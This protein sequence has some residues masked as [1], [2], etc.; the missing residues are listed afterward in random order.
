VFGVLDGHGGKRYIIL[1]PL[2]S[3][4]VASNFAKILKRMKSYK[5][6][7]YEQALIEAYVKFDELL[8]DE[9][10]NNFLREQQGQRYARSAHLVLDYRFE[11][12]FGGYI[13]SPTMQIEILGDNLSTATKSKDKGSSNDS[14]SKE[15]LTYGE[16]KLEISMRYL[17]ELK[18]DNLVATN[19]GTTANILLMKNNYLY[20][21]NVGDSLAVLFKNGEAIK[22]NNE[23]KTSLQSEYT[24]INKSGARIINNR[25]EGRLNLTRAI[26]N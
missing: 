13:K 19:M 20:L 23:H 3:K 4:F 1:G 6:K 2:V 15:I 7:N 24:R 8:R 26:G 22:L 14:K 5:E 16:S 18:P 17:H 12:E 9:K 10:V 21:A 25:I 11:V